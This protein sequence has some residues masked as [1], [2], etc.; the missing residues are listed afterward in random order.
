LADFV[1]NRVSSG[2]FK[3]ILWHLVH[4]CEQCRAEVRPHLAGLFGLSKPPEKRLL[5]GEDAEYDAALD[6]AFASA[7]EWSED[8]R[9]DCRNAA[10]SLISNSSWDDLPEIPLHLQGVPLFEALLEWSW[11]LRHDNPEE[12]LRIADWARVLAERLEPG[13]TDQK[14]I[15]DLQ[16]RA[17]VALGNAHRV[18]DDLLEAERALGRA[19]HLYLQGTGDESLA[20]NLFGAYG[21]LLGDL[22]SFSLAATALD[23]VFAIHS[24]RGDDHLAGRALIS[25]GLYAGYEGKSLESAQLIERG[26]LLIDEKRDPRL[27]LIAWHNQARALME[28]GE[29]RDARIALWKLKSR[30]LDLGGRINE[31][32]NLWL[33]GQINAELGELDRAEAALQEVVLG[34]EEVGLR[35]KAALVGLELGLIMFRRGDSAHAVE[36]VLA[37]VKVFQSLGIAREVSASVLLLRKAIAQAL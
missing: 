2:R 32:K 13:K 34:F 37:A 11:S 25:R 29:F 28:C 16:C 30:G 36:E 12:T 35:Y 19:M 15:T 26:L 1:W 18:A 24:R 6:R 3:T 14:V 17:W 33:E 4:G 20:A 7:L 8:L 22:R 27:L 5:P 23:L 21:S 10:L 31:L 9:E